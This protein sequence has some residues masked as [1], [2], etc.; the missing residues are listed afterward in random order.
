[1]KLEKLTAVITGASGNIGGSI[2]LALGRAGCNC[3]CHYHTNKERAQQIAK[4]IENSGRRAVSVQADL[5]NPEQI[6]KLFDEALGFDVPQIL[7]NSAG[8]FSSESLEKI[9]LQRARKVLDINLTASIL[10][11]KVFA[12]RLNEKFGQ[13]KEVVG[14]IINISGV[15]GIRP[16]AK[17]ILYC[18]SK[19]AL[20]GATKALAKELAPSVCVNSIAPGLFTWPPNFSEE[21]KKRQLSFIPLGRKTEAEDINAALIF[22]LKNDYITGQVLN[23]DGGRC[24]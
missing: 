3:I 17:Y 18:S 22:L 6:E 7:V 2:A 4:T 8:I 9:T 15:G 5:T 16:W 11:G 12:Q 14:K 1:M 23:V 21:Q 10:T 24:I 20:I 19:A 13:T